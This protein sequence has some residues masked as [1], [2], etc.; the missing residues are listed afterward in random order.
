MTISYNWLK[1]YINITETPEELGHLLT[2][3]GLEVESIEKFETIKGGLEGI[4]I[5]KVLTCAKHPYA[6]KL[7]VTTAPD[8]INLAIG[9][10]QLPRIAYNGSALER[11]LNLVKPLVGDPSLV[12]TLEQVLPMLPGADVALDVSLTGQPLA[13]TVLPDLNVTVNDDGSLSAFG[14]P[15]AA[16][17]FPPE[18]LAQLEAAGVGQLDVNISPTQIM[19]AANN[20]KL[21]VIEM[22]DGFLDTFVNDMGPAL[23]IDLGSMGGGV[24]ILQ[25]ILANGPLKTSVTLPGANAA[26]MPAEVDMSFEA[27]SADLLP[28]VIHLVLGYQDGTLASIGGLSSES[29]GSLAESFPTL[30]ENVG[31]MLA[32]MG[33]S[34]LQ[35]KT[36]ANKLNINIDGSTLLS[37]NYDVPSLMNAL[38]LAGPF[39]EDSPLGNPAMVQL[40]VDNILP[41]APGSDLDITINVQ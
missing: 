39:L 21:P 29:L 38:D 1:E 8:G 25:K 40:L 26:S 19:L 41:Y 30:P 3:T 35:L 20:E 24:G 10:L 15:L 32:G 33:A 18:L 12:D 34:Q 23:G 6:D 28:A 13:P 14:L 31:T 37:L 7:S 9:D 11:T 27:P 2:G 4:V 16:A 36:E 17:A 5:G 22:S